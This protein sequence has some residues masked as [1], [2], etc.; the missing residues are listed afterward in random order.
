MRKAFLVALAAAGVS[1]LSTV[2]AST[3]PVGGASALLNAINECSTANVEDVV[4]RCRRRCW[5][6]P[7]GF[8]R[9]RRVCHR[10]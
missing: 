8:V 5:R 9:C 6:T 2:S 4:W 10:W 7:G 3:A 1:L